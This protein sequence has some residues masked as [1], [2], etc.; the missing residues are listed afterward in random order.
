MRDV[1]LDADTALIP[2]RTIAVA[3]AEAVDDHRG[4]ALL[5]EPGREIEL[6]ARV[7]MPVP[8]TEAE[9]VK[10]ERHA[11]WKWVRCHQRAGD[12]RRSA[13]GAE[14]RNQRRVLDAHREAHRRDADRGLRRDRQ[15]E[16][17][18]HRADE[19]DQ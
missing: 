3:I 15:P 6:R 4:V 7:K 11:L 13:T 16:R 9:T 19:S 14:T 18:R 8:L 17:S 5:G 10:I 12:R 1:G 2:V